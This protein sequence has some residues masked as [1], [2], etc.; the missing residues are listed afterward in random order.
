MIFKLLFWVCF[1][2]LLYVFVGFVLAVWLVSKL[3]HK[4]AR[5]QEIM[6]S[7]SVII[8]AFNE[9]KHIR[10]KIANCLSLDYP[11]H[12]LEIIVVS[13]GSTDDTERILEDLGDPMIRIHRTSQRTGKTARQS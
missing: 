3:K 7:V 5:K 13:D 12:L 2:T 4:P 10:R 8:C 11:R 9:Q 1:G 6:P